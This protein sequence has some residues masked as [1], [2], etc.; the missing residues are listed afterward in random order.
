[1]S[2]YPN[3]V[4]KSSVITVETNECARCFIQLIGLNGEVLLTKDYESNKELNLNEYNLDP[5]VYILLLDN[6]HVVNRK[7]IVVN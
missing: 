5:G 2:I 1:M 6:G 7:R 3:P 4:S